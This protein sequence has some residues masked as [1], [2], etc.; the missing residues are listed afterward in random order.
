MWTRQ[1]LTISREVGYWHIYSFGEDN[2]GELYVL[3]VLLDSGKGA[4]YKMVP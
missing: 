3:T 2:A 1:K 4:L